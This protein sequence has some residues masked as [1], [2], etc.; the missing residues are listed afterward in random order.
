MFADNPFVFPSADAR[1]VVHNTRSESE[2]WLQE[3]ANQEGN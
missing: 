3:Q 1:L 2:F